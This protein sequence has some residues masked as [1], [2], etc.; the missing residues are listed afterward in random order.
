MQRDDRLNSDPSRRL[1][2]G[3]CVTFDILPGL[4]GRG[5][6]IRALGVGHVAHL[7]RSGGRPCLSDGATST[8]YRRCRGVSVRAH[9]F[10]PVWGC[11]RGGYPLAACAPFSRE[12]CREPAFAGSRRGRTDRAIGLPVRS[13]TVDGLK[14]D[15]FAFRVLAFAGADPIP[16]ASFFPVSLGLQTTPAGLPLAGS[17]LCLSLA[18]RPEGRAS[19]CYTSISWGSTSVARATASGIRSVEDWFVRE[20][21]SPGCKRSV[22]FQ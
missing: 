17:R 21:A 3:D 1:E 20:F 7:R 22:A 15:R 16:T 14:R 5:F 12:G 11:G 18:P 4:K 2:A 19:A 13:A 6:P 8:R 9:D 10:G